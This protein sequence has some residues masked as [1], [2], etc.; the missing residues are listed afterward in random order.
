MEK[1]KIMVANISL[2][3]PLLNMVSVEKN[4]GEIKH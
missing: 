4:C 3:L 1:D 2:L